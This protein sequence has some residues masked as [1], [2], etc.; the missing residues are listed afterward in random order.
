MPKII[1]EKLQ[2]YVV[3]QIKVRQ[4]THGS[5]TDGNTRSLNQI[6]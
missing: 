3:D 5:G 1:G 6:T 4:E 2:P